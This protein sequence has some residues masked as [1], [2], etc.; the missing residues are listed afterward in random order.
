MAANYNNDK[1]YER[2]THYFLFQCK[3]AQQSVLHELFR[4]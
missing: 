2:N 4:T 1:M 3:Q